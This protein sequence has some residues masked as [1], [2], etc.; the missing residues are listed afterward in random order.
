[1]IASD[2]LSLLS[3]FEAS[4]CNCD[5]TLHV[6]A[7]RQLLNFS[8]FVPFS[9]RKVLENRGQADEERV[10]FDNLQ[11]QLTINYLYLFTLLFCVC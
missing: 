9:V 10:S 1:M 2:S 6:A 7:I 8:L 11:F 3:C 4:S 5:S